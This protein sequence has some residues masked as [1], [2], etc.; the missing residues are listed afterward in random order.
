M[1]DLK[2]LDKQFTEI[3]NSFTKEDLKQWLENNKEEFEPPVKTLT[4]F[5]DITRE[6]LDYSGSTVLLEYD[7]GRFQVGS[8]YNWDFVD[9]NLNNHYIPKMSIKFIY[10]LK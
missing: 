5:K 6:F 9:N 2:K 8:L 4:K 1:L 3:L 7:D 10:L